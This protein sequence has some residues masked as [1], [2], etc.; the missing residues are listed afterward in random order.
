MNEEQAHAH[1]QMMEEQHIQDLTDKIEKAAHSYYNEESP[2]MSDHEFDQLVEELR[3]LDPSHPV[4]TAVG[5]GTK[6]SHVNDTEL[7]INIQVSLPKIQSTDVG[8]LNDYLRNDHHD[9]EYTFQVSP[10]LDG[11]SVIVTYE[12]NRLKSII[13]RGDGVRGMDLTSRFLPLIKEGNFDLPYI[14]DC[15]LDDVSL[16]IRGEFFIKKS[17]FDK[18]LSQDYANPRNATSGIVNSKSLDNKQHI[19]FL[20]HPQFAT[21][22]TVPVATT[23]RFTELDPFDLSRLYNEFLNEDYPIDGIVIDKCCVVILDSIAIKFPTESIETEVV[24]V[25]WQLS[26]K[27][28]Y[29][30][31]VEVKP[32]QLYGTTV[33]RVTGLHYDYVSRNGINAGAKVKVTKANEIIPQITEV[34]SSSE[35]K[36]FKNLPSHVIKGLHAMKDVSSYE[37]LMKVYTEN[38]TNNMFT[39]KGFQVSMLNKV[40]DHIGLVDLRDYLTL[41]HVLRNEIP[42]VRD[43]V[44]E[45]LRRVCGVKTDEFVNNYEN[46]GIQVC[47]LL[48]YIGFDGAG[49]KTSEKLNMKVPEWSRYLFND[50][51]YDGLGLPS[52][53]TSQLSD[54]TVHLVLQTIATMLRDRG[55]LKVTSRV[56]IKNDKPKVCLSGKFPN[57]TKAQLA[58]EFSLWNIVDYV[59]SS[60]E[61]LVVPDVSRVSS[62]VRKA[63]KLNISL[64]DLD[65]FISINKE[66]ENI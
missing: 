44:I 54:P 6:P 7:P 19:S 29:I 3:S 38:L 9:I 14:I 31:V 35:V 18:H 11:M 34:V 61:Y 40:R 10:K 8:R 66:K 22:P 16:T 20:Q 59:D 57:R 65:Q 47:D 25:H 45:D 60:I 26:S 39:F 53:I 27:N 37:D 5:F 30:P 42:V 63:E 4:L 50:V 58:E 1:Y 28:R 51:T 48:S 12:N 36:E 52:N 32:I 15:V 21:I 55:I 56:T 13:S 46:A 64:I 43:E 17:T 33:K 62:K 49:G 24:D 23:R 2:L 41:Y